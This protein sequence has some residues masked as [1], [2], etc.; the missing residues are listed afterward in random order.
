MD[1]QQPVFE[2]YSVRSEKIWCVERSALHGV[3]SMAAAETAGVRVHHNVSVR[4][5][6]P[7]SPSLLIEDRTGTR[8]VPCEHIV[9]CDGLRSVVRRSLP[10]QIAPDDVERMAIG[11][12]EIN[13]PPT[14]S[15][16]SFHYWPRGEI[17]FGAFPTLTGG[18]NGSLF[19]PL[20]GDQLSF[21]AV[22]DGNQACRLFNDIFADLLPMVPDLAEQFTANPVRTISTVRS[23]R[24]VFDDKV[25]LVGDA[26]HAMAPFM[27]HGMNCGFEDARILD[28]CLSAARGWTRSAL[29]EYERRRKPDAD[30]ITEISFEHYRHLAVPQPADRRTVQ[31]QAVAERIYR[32]YPK[33]FCSLYERCAFRADMSYARALSWHRTTERILDLLVEEGTGVTAEDFA[34]SLRGAIGRLPRNLHQPELDDFVSALIQS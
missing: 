32:T 28:E 8:R 23:E 11:Y 21:S 1:A 17:F 6:D 25:V 15:T 34:E 19:M 27:G 29:L 10:N 18:F 16:T 2:P 24:W 30:A 9:G 31:R 7:H 3:L 26:C 13:L 12:K 22:R 5:V 20:A 4:H 33:T 14:L